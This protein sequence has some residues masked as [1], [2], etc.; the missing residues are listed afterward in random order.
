MVTI[1]ELAKIE[2]ILVRGSDPR[3]CGDY[4]HKVRR[5]LAAGGVRTEVRHKLE[6]LAGQFGNAKFALRNS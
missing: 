5:W 1:G 6:Q 4:V 3:A 2:H